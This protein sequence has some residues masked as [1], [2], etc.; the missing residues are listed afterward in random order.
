MLCVGVT[1][2]NLAECSSLSF[3]HSSC[4]A[5]KEYFP[6]RMI[7]ATR[8]CRDTWQTMS[9]ASAARWLVFIT[10]KNSDIRSL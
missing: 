8:A 7:F 2:S 5:S 9:A 6:V 3:R 10:A 4:G 1:V